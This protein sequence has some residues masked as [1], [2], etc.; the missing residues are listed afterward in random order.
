MAA[1]GVTFWS[2]S[3]WTPALVMRFTA[4]QAASSR[5]G[6]S[7]GVSVCNVKGSPA[8]SASPQAL[9]RPPRTG[10]RLRRWASPQY[11]TWEAKIEGI[12]PISA[13]FSYWSVRAVWAWIITG[14]RAIFSGLS[15]ASR[16]AS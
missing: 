5:F 10:P 11:Q 16:A 9:T 2:S 4:H 8:R 1:Y 6:R 15:E 3:S 7:T 12:M 13:I 14:R